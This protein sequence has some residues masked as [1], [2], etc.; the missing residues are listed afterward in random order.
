[1]TMTS[2]FNGQAENQFLFVWP[3]TVVNP[4]AESDKQD[5]I[6]S[7][8]SEVDSVP[9]SYTNDG[10]RVERGYYWPRSRALSYADFMGCWGRR[11]IADC[12]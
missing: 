7:T 12:R 2:D 1:M 11:L 6:I 10:Y 5:R 4:G 8:L 3:E 9:G